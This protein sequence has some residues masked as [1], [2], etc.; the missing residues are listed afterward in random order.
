MH[1]LAEGDLGTDALGSC[2]LNQNPRE[3]LDSGRTLAA[4]HAR[5]VG[6]ALLLEETDDLRRI[7]ARGTHDRRV[8]AVLRGLISRI[9]QGRRPRGRYAATSAVHLYDA[10]RISLSELREEGIT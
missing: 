7:R 9:L 4:V 8:H 6:G 3:V 5:G 10:I 1:G 2:L